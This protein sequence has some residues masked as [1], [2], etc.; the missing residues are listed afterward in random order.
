M[1]RA[2]DLLTWRPSPQP[3]G[4]RDS[5]GDIPVRAASEVDRRNKGGRRR[6]RPWPLEVSSLGYPNNANLVTSVVSKK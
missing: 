1:F 2:G 4:D 5:D 3:L 6:L